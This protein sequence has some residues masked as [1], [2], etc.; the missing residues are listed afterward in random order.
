MCDNLS[1]VG[2]DAEIVPHT[3]EVAGYTAET[4]QAGSFSFFDEANK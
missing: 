2:V 1:S 4:V 3:Q